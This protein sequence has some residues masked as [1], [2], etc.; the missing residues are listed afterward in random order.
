MEAMASP[1]PATASPVVS[2]DQLPPEA[3]ALATRLFEA[4]RNG[5]MD[6]LEQALRGGLKPNMTNGKGDS[7]VSLYIFF[8]HLKWPFPLPWHWS[9]TELM[10]RFCDNL[11]G[12]YARDDKSL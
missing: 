12:C 3:L 10:E 9:L 8:S 6:I 11:Y 4:A 5:Q 7:L 2:V 1:P